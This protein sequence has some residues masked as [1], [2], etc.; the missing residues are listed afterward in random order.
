MNY[1][2][3]FSEIAEAYNIVTNSNYEMFAIELEIDFKDRNYEIVFLPTDSFD[4]AQK[5][6]GKLENAIDSYNEKKRHI[7]RRNIHRKSRHYFNECRHN[8]TK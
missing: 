3:Y 7:R 8:K 6:L 1:K 4:Y 2:K 5:Q